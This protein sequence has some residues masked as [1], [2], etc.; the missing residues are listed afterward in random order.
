MLSNLPACRGGDNDG[1]ADAGDARCAVGSGEHRTGSRRECMCYKIEYET[2]ESIEL[3][4][5]IVPMGS[6]FERF[7]NTGDEVF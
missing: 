4:T 2:A 5:P 3:R 6:L 1:G 7:R